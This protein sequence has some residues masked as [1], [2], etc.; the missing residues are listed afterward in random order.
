MTTHYYIHFAFFAAP[1]V[2]IITVSIGQQLGKY[3]LSAMASQTPKDNM[4]SVDSFDNL[5]Q[6]MPQMPMAICDGECVQLTNYY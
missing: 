2:H 1:G 5:P 6:L 3:E 4:Y